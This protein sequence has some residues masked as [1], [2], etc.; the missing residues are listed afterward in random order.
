MEEGRSLLLDSS[1]RM[2]QGKL[3]TAV[4]VFNKGVAF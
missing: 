3:H 2:T 4:A 1:I